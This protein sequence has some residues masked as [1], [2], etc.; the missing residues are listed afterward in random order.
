MNSS[1]EIYLKDF[2]R[3][4]A[5]ATGRA[6]G[7]QP[8]RSGQ[9]EYASSYH[10]LAHRVPNDA[11]PRTVLDLACGDGP[12]LRILNDRGHAQTKLIGVDMSD[13]ELSA[14][15]QGLPRGIRLLEERAQQMS[16]DSGS[17]DYV[18]SHMALML[19]DDIEQVI[20]EIRRVLRRNGTFSAVVGRTFLT[21]RIGTVFLDVFKPIAKTHLPRLP[22]GD[23]R[24]RSEGGWRELLGRE[25]VDVVFEDIE[26][27]WTPAPEQFW[28][29]MLD[30]YDA[31]RMPEEARA[32]LKRELWPALA[33]LQ[34]EN[35]RLQTGW[36]L[37]LIQATAA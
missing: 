10:A 30:T 27:D 23:A 36:G 35:G 34:D 20:R 25:F 31:D 2:H 12:L 6:F 3:R 32:R 19:M 7:D 9:A 14:A 8:A 13:G 1:A 26:I 5:G 28:L 18:L 21:G 11:M 29:E 33:P 24:T 16:L 4:R 22:L 37:R 17:V 15:R